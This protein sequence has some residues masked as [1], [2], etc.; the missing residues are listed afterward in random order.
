MKKEF[1]S[2][3]KPTLKDWAEEDRP[4]EKLMQKGIESLTSAELIAILI[5]S[6]SREE[7]AVELS[8][9]ILNSVENNLNNLG[10]LSLKDLS[11][12]KGIGEAKAISILAAMELGR[13]RKH[14]QVSERKQIKSSF[15]AYEFFQPLIAD[16]PYEEFWVV[17]LNNNLRIIDKAKIGQ[18]GISATV[19]DV[20]L[21]YKLA[22]E[23]LSTSIIVAHN[24]PSGSNQPSEIDKKLTQKLKQA[25]QTL[26]IVLS[27]HLIITD[28][29]YYS[30][31]DEGLI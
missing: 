19:S 16:L 26:D 7:N 11:K 28:R 1:E 30:F 15:D 6:G 4:R 18:G 22:L 24:H 3:E 20:R 29:N 12:F 17:F 9:R 8:K 31:A 13:R 5:G 14:E 21:I 25:G 23:K 27:D 10:K 2:A